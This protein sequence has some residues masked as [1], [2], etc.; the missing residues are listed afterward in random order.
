VF[1]SSRRNTC[2]RLLDHLK[3]VRKATGSDTRWYRVPENLSYPIK[4]EN[5]HYYYRLVQKIV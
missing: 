4:L 2:G 3:G 5:V 1:C